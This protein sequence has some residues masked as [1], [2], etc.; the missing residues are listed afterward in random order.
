MALLKKKEI[1]LKKKYC[2]K[3]KL[4][5]RNGFFQVVYMTLVDLA[6]TLLIDYTP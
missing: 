2:L 1:L 5:E 3:A 4:S 6:N